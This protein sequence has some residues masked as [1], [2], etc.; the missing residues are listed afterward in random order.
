MKTFSQLINEVRLTKR[1][2]QK[3]RMGFKDPN[4]QEL[5]EISDKNIDQILRKAESDPD[6]LSEPDKTIL[7]ALGKKIPSKAERINYIKA[8][9][10]KFNQ[11]GISLP[12]VKKQRQ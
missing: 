9:A 11:L 7:F 6:S 12:G 10:K 3:R 5:K 8:L 4:Q 2:S 1:L